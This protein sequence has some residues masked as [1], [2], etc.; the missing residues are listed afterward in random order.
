ME[1]MKRSREMI[2][3]INILLS[4]KAGI[5]LP[6]VTERVWK[7]TDFMGKKM[8]IKENKNRLYKMFNSL[9]YCVGVL[10]DIADKW[11]VFQGVF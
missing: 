6:P 3:N 4:W 10:F 5:R 1:R 9:F 8:N 2:E 7:R 11:Q